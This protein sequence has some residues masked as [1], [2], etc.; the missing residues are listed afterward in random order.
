MNSIVNLLTAKIV[1]NIIE[2]DKF[3][4]ALLYYM[5]FAQSCQME[6]E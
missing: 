2:V 5:V 6:H 4:N 3:L 1:P